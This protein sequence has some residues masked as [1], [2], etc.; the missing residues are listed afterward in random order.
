MR[1]RPPF[2]L[3]E[4][5]LE[6][7]GRLIEVLGMVIPE[8]GIGRQPSVR[9]RLLGKGVGTRSLELGDEKVRAPTRTFS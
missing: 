7:I 4:E 9:L 3:R 5:R 6:L 2:D 1:K 8:G